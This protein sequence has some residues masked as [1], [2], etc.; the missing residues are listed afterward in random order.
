MRREGAAIA[1]SRLMAKRLNTSVLALLPL[2]AYVCAG[3]LVALSETLPTLTTIA[4]VRRLSSAEA[5]RGYPI[6]LRAVVTYFDPVSPDLFLHDR[7]GGIWVKWSKALPTASVGQVLDLKGTSTQADFAP[8]IANPQWKVIGESAAPSPRHVTFDEM[9]STDEDSQWVEVEGIVRQ[10]AHLHDTTPVNAIWLDV[11]LAGGRIDVQIPWTGAPVP[12]ELVDRR[13]RIRGV[14]GAEFNASNQLVGVQLYV[15]ELKDISP[16]EPP[17]PDLFAAP[18][19]PIGE[20]QRFGIH[21]PRG[22]RVKLTGVVTADMPGHGFYIK[23]QTGTVYVETRQDIVLQPGDQVETLGFMGLFDSRLR[24]E[25][26]VARR[27]GSGRPFEPVPITVTQAMSG[28]FDSELISLQGRLVEFSRLRREE[29]LILEENHKIF[30]I[31]G[32]IG[33]FGKT[34]EEGSLLRVSGI[35]VNER[36]SFGHVTGFR[37]IARSRRD[38]RVLQRPAWWTLGRAAVLIGGLLALTLIVITWVIVLRGRVQ[39]QTRVITQKLSQEESLRQAAQL[40]NHAKSEFLANMSHEIRTPMN[41][42]IG[43]T[44]LVLETDLIDDQ[45]EHLETVRSCARGLLTVI[46][47]ILDFS[48]I[49]ADKLA[50]DPIVFNLEDALGEAL[51]GLAI[52]AYHKG[53]ELVCQIVPDVP[54]E[55][56]GDPGR[57]RQVVVNLIGNALKFTKTG[58]VVLKVEVE[59]RNET[60]V[61]LHFR[62]IDTGIGIPP[63]KQLK[64]FEAFT[65]ADGGTTRQFGGTGLGLTISSRLVEMFGGRLWVESETGLGSTFHFTAKFGQVTHP[66]PRPKPVDIQNVPVLVVDDNGTNRRILLETLSGWSMKVM[67]AE[68]GI[69]ALA[70]IEGAINAGDPFPLVIVDFQ[71]PLMDGFELVEHIQRY[72]ESSSTKYIMLSSAGQR[73]DAA[74]CKTLGIGGYLSKPVK[75]SDLLRC[76]LSVLGSPVPNG[77]SAPLVTRHSLREASRHILL[78]EDNLVNQ[79][80]ALRLLEKHGH[81][82]VVANNGRE[83]VEALDRESFDVVLMDVQMPIMDG[84]EATALIRDKERGKSEHTRIIAVTAYAMNGDRERCLAAGMD[85][86]ICKPI[87]PNKLREVLSAPLLS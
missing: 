51:R 74:R 36:D 68:D 17:R 23:D 81:T 19:M 44:D 41:G 62:I 39:K 79:R 21:Q 10:T 59:A 11:A 2:G 55:L 12:S 75:P 48:K 56:I 29:T 73:G 77:T 53:L 65:Q 38:V 33:V 9:A 32:R 49:E 7:T 16:L 15:P 31:S 80:L 26:A 37:L 8:D 63:E 71:M 22:H 24:L 70:Q 42:I 72:P 58:E 85:G 82:V 20:L 27:I 34:P 78:A 3:Q 45:R 1:R 61:I 54:A 76:I 67:L 50:L 43:M 5:R 35:C 40:A 18:S 86:Y 64:I 13:V 84:F 69:A 57:L 28:T 6:H 66:I 46:N 30:S 87:E 25:Q 47:D 4:Q 83:A 14:C 60:E 52:E